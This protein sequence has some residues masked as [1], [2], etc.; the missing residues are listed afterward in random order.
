VQGRGV[1]RRRPG[2]VSA[3]QRV[4]RSGSSG[5]RSRRCSGWAYRVAQPRVVGAL[6]CVGAAALLAAPGFLVRV[7]GT[8]R[9]EGGR[10]ENRGGRGNHRGGDG[11]GMECNSPGVTAT[12][13]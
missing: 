10:R 2:L 6:G 3:L 12:K 8:E 4:S 1:A 5:A 11:L 13:T 9:S 7:V